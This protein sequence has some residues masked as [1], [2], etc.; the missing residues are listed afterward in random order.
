MLVPVIVA[1]F[2]SHA[3][4]GVVPPAPTGQP[5]AAAAQAKPDAP[6]PPPGVA[7]DDKS[8]VVPRLI[9]ERKPSYTGKAR[10]N[11]IQGLVGLEAVVNADGTVGEVRV[12]R[13]L[14]KE[15]GLD[16]EA[17]KAVKDWRFKPG[18]RDGVP[19]PVLVEIEMTFTVR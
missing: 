12:V 8:V 9:K 11:K 10:R 14:D 13:S 18:T 1:L 17:V 3:S 7:R 4:A 19:V 5:P 2:V 16:D 6:W 15:F